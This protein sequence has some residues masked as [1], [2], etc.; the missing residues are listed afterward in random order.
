MSPTRREPPPSIRG[1]RPLKTRSAVRCVALGVLALATASHAAPV[2]D[3]VAD[4]AYGAALSVQTTQTSFGDNVNVVSSGSE[5]DAA[6][7]FVSEGKL[8][9]VIAGSFNRF[10]S[11]PLTFPNQVHVFIDSRSGG[12]G[13]LAGNTSPSS[14]FVRIQDVTG[15]AFDPDFV[16]DFWFGAARNGGDGTTFSTYACELPTA[17]GGVGVL[18][19][20]GVLGGTGTLSGGSN[21]LGILASLDIS[22]AAGVTQGCGAGAGAGVTTGF[23]WGIPLAAIGNPSG[24]I[25]ICAVLARQGSGGAEV[26]NQILGPV[27]PGTCSLGLANGLNLGTIPGSQ[28]FVLDVPIPTVRATW[29]ALRAR[30]R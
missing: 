14:S 10:Y 20:Q 17:S 9:L 19:G 22:N 11:E 16:P 13:F 18:L 6:H 24:P 4:P 21:P 25:R 12:Q 30:Y 15:L 8:W 28:Y 26:S 5:L 7:A 29:G 3:G 23:E 2:V 27:P 1:R